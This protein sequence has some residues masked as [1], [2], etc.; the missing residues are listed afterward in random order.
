MGT[1]RQRSSAATVEVAALAPAFFNFHIDAG[2]RNP[3]V[4]LHAGGPPRHVRSL[5]HPRPAGQPHRQRPVEH[6]ERRPWTATANDNG[7]A[8]QIQARTGPGQPRTRRGL[9][10]FGAVLRIEGQPDVRGAVSVDE[11]RRYG[12]SSKSKSAFATIGERAKPAFVASSEAA[13]PTRA[14]SGRR[15]SKRKKTVSI[16]RRKDRMALHDLSRARTG[17]AII[18]S[19]RMIAVCSRTS[20]ARTAD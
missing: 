7:A 13:R 18:S 11:Q 15:L 16:D 19:G 1:T 6:R 17:S 10:R 9:G 5:T 20:K 4:A 14:A 8:T 12:Q 3:I 2:G